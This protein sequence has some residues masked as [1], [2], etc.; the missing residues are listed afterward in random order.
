VKR[1]VLLLSCVLF[2]TQ[3][4]AP[5]THYSHEHDLGSCESSD[6]SCALGTGFSWAE[7]DGCVTKSI[8]ES[9]SEKASFELEWGRDENGQEDSSEQVFEV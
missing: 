5:H 7:C 1:I 8:P 9:R 2:S 4:L 3:L 6:G